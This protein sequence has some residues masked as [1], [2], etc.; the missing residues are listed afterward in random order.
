M[1]IP[2]RAAEFLA[3]LGGMTLA[4][5]VLAAAL[6]YAAWRARREEEPRWWAAPLTAALAMLAVPLLVVPL[7]ALFDRQGPPGMGGH[8]GFYPSGHSAT[9]TVAYGAAVL[10]LAPYVRSA[11]LRREL[12]IG[13]ALLVAAVGAGLVRRGYHWPLDVV[14]SWALGGMLL[15]G[16]VTGARYLRRSTEE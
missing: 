16:A 3:D 11:Y 9:A 10:L 7:K 12:L 5:P 15:I 4:L 2:N 6:A 14:A 1:G 8:G 13:G